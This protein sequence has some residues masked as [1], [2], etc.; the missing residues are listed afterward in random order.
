MLQ[1]YRQVRWSSLIPG[2]FHFLDSVCIPVYRAL[3]RCNEQ[4]GGSSGNF[5]STR[6][7]GFI[8]IGWFDSGARS[9]YTTKMVRR[10]TPADLKA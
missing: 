9:I 10:P 7:D 5:E 3:L 2:V 8:A 1:R 6:K 4:F